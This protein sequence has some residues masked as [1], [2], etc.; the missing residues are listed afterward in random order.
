MI[1]VWAGRERH[2]FWYIR[3]SL[4]SLL[5]SDLPAT[6]RIFFI[7]DQSTDRRLQPFLHKL[8]GQDSR[9]E[10]WT[11]PRRM[12][13]NEGQA[14][15]FPRVVERFP[16]TPYFVMSDDDVIYHPGWLQR[17]IQ[18][19]D[20]AQA[21]NVRGVF[22][23]L[24]LVARRTLEEKQFPTSTAL[25]KERSPALNW[26]LPRDVYEAVGP[27]RDT[28]VAFDTDYQ[29]RLAAL[30]MHAICLKP[31]WVQNIGYQGAYQSDDTYVAPDYVGRRH[32]QLVLRDLKYA[33]HRHTVGRARRT[34]D[35]LP[36]GAVKRSLLGLARGCRDLVFRR[37]KCAKG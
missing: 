3:H 11:N 34:L 12:G 13:P 24:N 31:S 19:Q 30:G 2:D 36:E 8:A 4:A 15:N 29:D 33:L 20:E 35:G 10:V 9:V 22:T 27:F 28:G 16:D 7:D 25:V 17:L 6:A 32:W 23:A 37:P 21:A 26:L 1:K 14:Y 18:V 5:R